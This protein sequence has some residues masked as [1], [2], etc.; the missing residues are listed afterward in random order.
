MAAI[1]DVI[2]SKMRAPKNHG[3]IRRL[4]RVDPK[5]AVGTGMAPNKAKIMASANKAEGM[6][7]WID[8]VRDSKD[9][10]VFNMDVVEEVRWTLAGPQTDESVRKNFGATIDLFGAGKSPQDID[11][12]E[13]TMAQTG[14][15]Q[16]HFITCYIG[17]HL[18]PEPLCFTQVGNAWTSPVVG[19]TAP[20]SP[21]VFTQN[22]RYNGAL[23]AAFAGATPTQV[24]FP[25]ILQHGWWANYAFWNLVRGY[26]LRW[27]VGQHTNIMDEVARHT[28]YMPPNA[29]DGSA[30]NS[31]VDTAQFIADMNER[32]GELGSALTFLKAN[33]IRIG[34]VGTGAA[35]YGIFKPSR[36]F[37]LVGATFGGMDL[38][39]LLKGNSEFRQLALPYVI[40]AGVPIGLELQEVDTIQA[41]RMREY[42]SISN[43]QGGAFPPIVTDQ[44]FINDTPDG[45]G[46]GNVGLERTLDG[47][48]V[49]Q[50]QDVGR[51]VYKSG[52]AKITLSIKGFEVTEQW[53]T[54]L[55][56][57]PDL[58]AVVQSSC[59]IHFATT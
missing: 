51:A 1:R 31:E 12:V 32:Y 43:G 8:A 48:N 26:N 15:T 28:A 21:D 24:I 5:K 3:E 49:P 57:D 53:Y 46:A 42:L 29:Q 7:A 52:E 23:G 44:D 54:M 14:E 18:D 10:P 50:Q 41:D 11:Y 6:G 33:R 34:S 59:G 39:S 17:L 16:T 38:R 2:A 22:D 35:N 20:V 47:Y 27:K 36:D 19:A 4:P 58:L 56:S 30:S 40:R 37:D 55:M 13:T 9:C 45:T 25:A